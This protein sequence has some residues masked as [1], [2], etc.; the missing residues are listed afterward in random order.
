MMRSMV[1]RVSAA[2]GVAVL[3]V[4][5]A[6]AQNLV[7]NGDFDTGIDG[8]TQVSGGI[9]LSWDGASDYQGQP[10]SG[11]AMVLNN[12][13]VSSNSGAIGCVE[14]IIGAESYDL[15]AW[16][17]A[18]TGQSADGNAR[19]FVWWYTEPGCTGTQSWGPTTPYFT[20]S[21]D[22]VLQQAA[23]VQAPLASRSATVY[24]NVAKTSAV[25]GEYLVS[26][27]HVSFTG[28]SVDRNLSFIPAAGLA[29]GDA[30][31]FWVTDLDVNNS[32]TG[33]M[34]YELWWLPRG[35][36][37]SE[38]MRSELFTLDSEESRRHGNVLGE[39][40]DLDP[41]DAPFG[42]LAIA[43]DREG[44]LAMARVF[45]QPLGDGVGTFG[46][47]IPGVPA[48]AMIRQDERQRILFMSE[49]DELRAN[50]GCQNGTAANLRVMIE[51]FDASGQSYGLEILDLPPYSNNQINRIFSDWAPI[52]G[53]VDVWSTTSEARFYCYG[54]VLDN[55]SSDPTTVL[56]Q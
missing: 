31:S 54:S 33:A 1:V 22:W 41:D 3:G 26:F 34:T 53:Y 6:A 36:D 20:T 55:L 10:T 21:D 38:P 32:N 37:N 11:S 7:V 47:A 45:N 23:S 29:P 40:F 35:E 9:T 27:D 12:A 25:P 19:V 17:K 42:A 49:D 5:L 50:V 39:V 13:S 44:T 28:K 56:P 14:G 18:S 48:K 43:S 30:G 24:L 46:Q 8:W 2:V 16:L 52:S 51:L 4:S 15:S